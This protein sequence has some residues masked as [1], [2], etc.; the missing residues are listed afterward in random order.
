MNHR[1]DTAQQIRIGVARIPLPFIRFG[2]RVA[3]QVNHPMTAGGQEGGQ[4]RPDQPGRSADRDR[5][6]LQTLRGGAAVHGDVV[7]QLAMPVGEHRAQRASRHRCGDA[8]GDPGAFTVELLEFVGM[9]PADRQPDRQ[10][11]RP[12]GA[13]RVDE[14]SR[15][16]VEIRLM[17]GHPAQTAGKAELSTPVF[18]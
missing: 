15:R 9:P 12:I 3:H 18:Q 2:C 5:Y 6:R 16:I 8:V 14:A 4:R 7:G 11:G 17:V 10:R 1:V 13:D